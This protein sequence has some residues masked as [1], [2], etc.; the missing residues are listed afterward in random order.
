MEIIK[1]TFSLPRD[2]AREIFPKGYVLKNIKTLRDKYVQCTFALAPKKAKPAPFLHNEMRV[3][4]MRVSA[5]YSQRADIERYVYHWGLSSVRDGYAHTG[6]DWTY[7]HSYFLTICMPQIVRE[8]VRLFRGSMEK[9]RGEF[10]QPFA[11]I[12]KAHFD[13]AE[14]VAWEEITQYTTNGSSHVFRGRVFGE[15]MQATGW[16]RDFLGLWRPKRASKVCF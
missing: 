10:P 5:G 6:A 3:K 4:I 1:V 2:N 14:W 15:D 7:G 13:F 9:L 8:E 16:G 11:P 12:E